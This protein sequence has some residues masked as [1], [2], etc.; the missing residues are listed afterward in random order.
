[1]RWSRRSWRS[2][3]DP[4]PVVLPTRFWTAGAATEQGCAITRRVG[5]AWQPL[6][7][8]SIRTW[9][10]RVSPGYIA[11]CRG[12]PGRPVTRFPAVQPSA[13]Y[14]SV[15]MLTRVL[16]C[17]RRHEPSASPVSELGACAWDRSVAESQ[18]TRSSTRTR[19]ARHRPD[20]AATTRDR[21]ANGQ[22]KLALP[23]R[24]KGRVQRHHQ[25]VEAD[26]AR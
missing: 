12:D 21:P 15:S 20:P 10:Q 1:M 8:V 24:R 13:L 26:L 25:P 14:L 23:R 3:R 6:V 2:L 4:G 5:V 22:K 17:V 9:N 7:R 19:I 18:G 16:M 11:G